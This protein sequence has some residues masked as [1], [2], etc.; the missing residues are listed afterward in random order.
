[1]KSTYKPLEVIGPEHELSLINTDLLALPISDKV[2]KEYCGKITNFVELP[3]FTFGKE[4]QLHVIEIKGNQPFQSPVEFD[5]IMQNGV[6]H[7]SDF[8]KKKFGASLLGTGMHPL[9]CLNETGIWPHYHRKIYQEYGRIFNLKQ[10]GWLN[11]QSFHLNLSY[12]KEKDGVLLHNLL[13]NICPYLPAISSA[14]PIYEGRIHPAVDNRLRFYRENQL[15]VP[16][17]S[18]KIVPEYIS[19]FNDYRKNVIGKYSSDLAKAGASNALLL[20]EWVNSRGVIFRFDRRALEV[21]VMDEQE[22]I[23]S[24]VALSC[25]VRACLR[26]LLI[27]EAELLPNELLVNDFNV[28]INDGLNAKVQHPQGQT[29]RQVCNYLYRIA[30]EH[31]Q[32]EEKKYL[33]IIEKRIENGSISDLIR[34]NV[35]KKLRDSDSRE[36]IID[37]YSTLIKCLAT[38]Q[39][40]F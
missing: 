36:A 24:D 3:E 40:Y 21:R 17:V 34:R 22:C 37:V 38:N 11:I 33:S 30:W 25:F 12:Q 9:L 7:L 14:S 19:S 29:A 31:A 20:K 1:V 5:E 18:G 26:G 15:E 35:S 4:M 16:S 28:V 8:V 2:I 27:R 10:H 6:S 39:P 32:D 23:K 13:T